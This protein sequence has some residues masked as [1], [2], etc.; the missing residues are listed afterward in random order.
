MKSLVILSFMALIIT[1]CAIHTGSVSSSPLPNCTYQGM[2]NAKVGTSHFLGI[3][4]N[5]RG[6][7]IKDAKGILLEENRGKGTVLTNY[8]LDIK[9]TFFIVTTSTVFTLSAE[10]YFCPTQNQTA[11]LAIPLANNEALKK[12]TIIPKEVITT[13]VV[14]NVKP[15]EIVVEKVN[16]EV[17]KQV[18]KVPVVETNRENRGPFEI[19]DPVYFLN[20]GVVTKAVITMIAKKMVRVSYQE[21]AGEKV[22]NLAQTDVYQALNISSNETKYGYQIGKT[23]KIEVFV[24]QSNVNMVREGTI[25][26]IG[27]AGIILEYPKED[28]T[29]RKVQ[30]PYSKIL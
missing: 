20:D 8:S 16:A 13:T 25:I 12:D 27:K 29:T 26:G 14:E 2:V 5:T 9:R 7:L 1:S 19:N 21:G 30:V 10:K 15:V 22:A 17:N 24:K 23:A 3:G 18:E 11:V 6:A 28:G 4:G